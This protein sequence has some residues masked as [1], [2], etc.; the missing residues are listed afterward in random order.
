MGHDETM[1]ARPRLRRT[2]WLIV[3]LVV[4][5]QTLAPRS[6]GEMRDP[7]PAWVGTAAL[8]TALGQ[9][10]A[11]IWRR[12]EPVRS[13]VAV[14]TLYA[15]SVLAVGAVPP[16]APWV[17]IWALATKLPGW[18]AAIRTA[19]LGAVTT[20]VLLLVNELVR[21][22]TGA[23][24]FL[25][26]ITVVV[27][28]SAVLIRSERGRLD[29]VRDAATAEERLRIARDM[30][31]LVGHGLSAVAVQSSTARLALSKGDAPTALT[32][33]AAVESSS[34]A[35][36]REMRHLLGVLTS[37]ATDSVRPD[38]PA[39]GLLDLP[40]LIDNV[41]AGGV[42]ITWQ[43]DVDP[44]TVSPSVQLSAYRIAQEALTNAVKHSP[45]GVVAVSVLTDREQVNEPGLLLR[46]QT[47]GG[48]EPT[49]DR[50]AASADSGGLGIDGIRARAGSVGGNAHVA[51]TNDG[52]LVE[53]RLPA[54]AVEVR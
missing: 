48:A 7:D 6:G 36:M 42:A 30:H 50:H 21:A 2:D 53:A 20:V 1:P 16:L 33:L 38:A 25:S 13:A 31:D 4:V 40:A 41:R 17:A 27:C 3:A 28:L 22:G 8:L 52:W 24:V 47:T 23:S 11:L 35:A 46:V 45:G 29:A 39:P 34:R 51:A 9:A 19:G 44:G 49:H 12:R 32:A 54:A 14:M 10:G 43:T 37:D 18:R 26:A 15:V 5:L